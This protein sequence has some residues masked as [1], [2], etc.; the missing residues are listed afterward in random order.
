[1]FFHIWEKGHR[2]TIWAKSWNDLY[3]HFKEWSIKPDRVVKLV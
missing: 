1:M 2:H 3:E